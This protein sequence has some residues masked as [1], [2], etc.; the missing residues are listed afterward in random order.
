MGILMLVT[1]FATKK[2]WLKSLS[3]ISIALSIFQLL[4]LF[5]VSL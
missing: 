5:S 3:V 1:G 4:Y 2:K